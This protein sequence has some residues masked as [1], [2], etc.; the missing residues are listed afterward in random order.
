M[1]ESASQAFEARWGETIESTIRNVQ[2]GLLDA[3]STLGDLPLL[4]AFTEL[5]NAT[6]D[7]YVAPTQNDTSGVVLYRITPEHMSTGVTTAKRAYRIAWALE[8]G[9]HAVGQ[10]H[11]T[12]SMAPPEVREFELTAEEKEHKQ[13]SKEE[14]AAE[15]AAAEE[16]RKEVEGRA[17]ERAAKVAGGDGDAAG[18]GAPRQLRVG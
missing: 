10:K 1:Q 3:S 7:V 14:V 15:E 5:Y 13:R 12:K 2:S 18:S 8:S 6:V 4:D 16:A 17:N 11:I 9:W